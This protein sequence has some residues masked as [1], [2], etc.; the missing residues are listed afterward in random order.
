M[1]DSADGRGSK[2]GKVEQ[3]AKAQTQDM[4]CFNGRL[5]SRHSIEDGSEYL[6]FVFG[7]KNSEGQACRNIGVVDAEFIFLSGMFN[8]YEPAA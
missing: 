4:P 2:S 6:H 1:E 7:G 8:V 5:E 3:V